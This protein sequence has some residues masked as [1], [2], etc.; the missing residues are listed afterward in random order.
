MANNYISLITKYS[1]KAFDKVYKQESRSALLDAPSA[2]VQWTGAKTVKIGKFQSGGLNNYYRNNN[3]DPRVNTGS[4]PGLYGFGYQRSQVGF[5]WEEFTVRQDRGAQYPIELFDNE[6]TDGNV[7]AAATTEIS[8]TQIIP[9]VD[10]YCFSEIASKCSTDLGNLA[11]TAITKSNVYEEL[12]KGLLYMEEHEVEADN[13]IIFTSPALYNTLRNANADMSRIVQNKE[14]KG[15][16]FAM[17]EYEGRDIVSVAPARFRTDIDLSGEGVAWGANSKAIDF[18]ILAKD[19]VMHVVKYNKVKILEGDVVTALG[20]DGYL[21]TARIYHDVFVQD[22]KRYAIYA[23]V[24]DTAALANKL[25]VDVENGAI[26][27]IVTFP[28]DKLYFVGTSTDTMA[29]GD[30]ATAANFTVSKVGDAVSQTTA[31]YA[32]DSNYKVVAK[33]TVT[34]A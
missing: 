17:G 5:I 29:V 13:T 33:Y 3:G 19:A 12:N 9:E 27:A 25:V 10:A 28:G 22:N 34:I 7:L 14:S 16:N 21:L 20:F 18:L 24:S 23:H 32:V 8:R 11:T 31:F 4:T 1:T 30:T 6:E 26:S 15:V 2:N